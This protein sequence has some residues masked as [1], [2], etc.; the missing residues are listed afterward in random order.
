M[1]R[2]Q[3]V[4]ERHE[5][6]SWRGRYELVKRMPARS[7]KRQL[8]I[9]TARMTLFMDRFQAAMLDMRVDLSR[10]DTGVPQHFL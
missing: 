7:P 1:A 2:G 8:A 9:S 4:D 3:R 10:P 5:M 6:A